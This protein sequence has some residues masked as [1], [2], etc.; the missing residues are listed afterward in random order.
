M[1]IHGFGC[2][3]INSLWWRTC[4]EKSENLLSCCYPHA[5]PV[6][7]TCTWLVHITCDSCA[8]NLCVS[9]AVL[10]CATYVIL[11]CFSYTQDFSFDGSSLCAGTEM[12]ETRVFSLYWKGRMTLPFSHTRRLKIVSLLLLLLLLFW[13]L[14][15]SK[16]FSTSS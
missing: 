5:H 1:L 4:L 14:G 16:P 9:H 12:V 15:A 7:F 13:V 10:M 2:S 11:V 6:R 8:H 3:Q